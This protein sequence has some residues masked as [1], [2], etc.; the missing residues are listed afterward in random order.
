[1]KHQD[2]NQISQSQHRREA[3]QVS[4]SLAG[5]AEM[6]LVPCPAPPRGAVT[7]EPDRAHPSLTINNS[8]T[9]I[10]KGIAGYSEEEKF[11]EYQNYKDKI[12][13]LL[14]VYHRKGQTR[15]QNVIEQA[16]FRYGRESL[17]VIDLTFGQQPNGDPPSFD[18]ANSCLN[19]LLTN[20]FR[21]RYSTNEGGKRWNNFVVVCERGGK[22]GRV[23]FHI[24]VVKEGADFFTGS[25]KGKDGRT[26][27]ETWHPNEECKRE[28]AFLRSKVQSYGFG[29]RVKVAPLWNVEKG[30]R[31]FTKYVGKGHY[32]RTEEMKHRQLVRYGT[33]FKR[34]HSMKFSGVYGAPR[35]RRVVLSK[36]GERYGCESITELN[37]VF[38]S[39]WQYYAGDQMR[40]ASA[41]VRGRLLPPQTIKFLND[42]LWNAFK[43]KLIAVKRKAF[44]FEVIGAYKYMI[45]EEHAREWIGRSGVAPDDVYEKTSLLV[46]DKLRQY[47]WR[48]LCAKIE[49]DAMGDHEEFTNLPI[50]E[51]AFNLKQDTKNE[52]E[53]QRNEQKRRDCGTSIEPSGQL[54][55]DGD[56]Y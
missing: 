36:L 34:W 16:A 9:L 51:E 6:E 52:T 10:D 53:Q 56:I 43:L 15:L 26:G 29:G 14:S 25:Y 41:M 37:E 17:A 44:K 55:L 13:P 45:R 23:H 35:D 46:A 2:S 18:Y 33:G 54:E 12:D 3:V 19:S 31:Y 20:I 47:S 5:S 28:W 42:Y 1:M 4:H 49:C 39:R 7:Q 21:P 48:N 27:R 11:K 8:I 30:A 24:L 40:F 22:R 50:V 38:G 32:S